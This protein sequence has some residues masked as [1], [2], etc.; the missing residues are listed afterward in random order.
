MSVKNQFTPISQSAGALL[1]RLA[2]ATV[3]FPHGCQLMFGMFG[4]P[5]FNSAISYFMNVEGLP[6][7]IGFAVIFL[8]FFGSIF[9]LFGLLTRA[10]SVNMII[11][12]TGMILTSHLE[13]GFFMNWFGTQKGE[14]FEYHLLVLG[15]SLSLVAT[16][17]GSFSLDKLLERNCNWSKEII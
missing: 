14:G 2:L 15:M 9:L 4:G 13:H 12:F 10:V 8:Q 7:F 3:I 5:G 1:L 17:G 11:L 16:G 6:A